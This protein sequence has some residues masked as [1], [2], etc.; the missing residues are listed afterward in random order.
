MVVVF[1]VLIRGMMVSMSAGVSSSVK[2]KVKVRPQ[3]VAGRLA[4]LV[5]MAKRGA[6]LSEHHARKQQQAYN[7]LSHVL[8]RLIIQRRVNI[9][10][11][12]AQIAKRCR[13]AIIRSPSRSFRPSYACRQA[14][15]YLVEGGDDKQPAWF[16]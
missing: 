13:E 6:G 7:T 3:S 5:R 9:L 12:I 16:R 14:A 1:P 11:S 15:V 2:R 4:A 8:T 10:S